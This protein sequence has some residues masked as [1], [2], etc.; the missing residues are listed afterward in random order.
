[1]AK[2]KHQ[3]HCQQCGSACEIYKKGKGHRVMV[4]PHHGVIATNPTLAGSLLKGVVS[5]IP[6]VGGIAS[7][8]IGG[9]QEQHAQKQAQAPSFATTPSGEKRLSS[10]Q[11]ALMLEALER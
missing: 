6:M 2:K 1:M 11:K 3:F 9:I 4:C 5:G 10:F 7:G 8:I